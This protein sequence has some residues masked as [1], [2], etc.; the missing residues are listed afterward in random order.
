VEQE[1]TV[2]GIHTRNDLLFLNNQRPI[3]AIGWKEMGDV[4]IAGKDK[5]KMKDK[6]QLTYPDAPKGAISTAVGMISRFAFEVR[7]GDYVVFPSKHNRMINLGVITSDYFFDASEEQYPNKR[8]VKW[9]KSIS[10]ES[11]SQGALY[12]VGSALTF[13]TVKNYADEFLG[14]LDKNFISKPMEDENL[15]QI[16]ITA[17]SILETTK[18]FVIKELSKRLK[19]YELEEFIANLLNAMGYKTALSKKGG[20]SGKDIIAY[21]DEL[22]P[23]ILVQVK[24]VDGNITESTLQSLKGAMSEGDYG[25]FVTLSN[26][27]KNA[28]AYLDKQPIIKAIS[29]SELVDLILKYYDGLDKKYQSILPLKKVYIPIAE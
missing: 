2:W 22:P 5:E 12:E 11:F 15:E 14:A 18:D 7:I 9:L 6:Y 17:E 21:K 29:G 4:S 19:G 25:L 28:K 20:D 27:T 13:F 16:A 3:I 26:Y 1:Q 8:E 23:R 10:R 24:S